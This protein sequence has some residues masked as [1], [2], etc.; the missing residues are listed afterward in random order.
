MSDQFIRTQKLLGDSGFARLQGAFVVVVGLGAVGSYAV[1]ALARSGVGRMRLIDFDD[2]SITNIN[3]QLY[4]LHSTIGRRKA[5]LAAERVRDINPDCK[6]EFADTFVHTDTLD[7]VLAGEPDVVID[8]I[9]SLN[10]K[11]ALLA[12]VMERG[13]K[14]FSSMGAA[15]RRDP[16]KVVIGDI[17]KTMNCPLARLVR[18]RLRRYH[19]IKKGITCVSSTE[20]AP[21]AAEVSMEEDVTPYTGRGRAR[22]ALGSLPTITGIFGLTLA[23]AVIDYLSSEK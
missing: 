21:D 2:V 17:S 16:T 18:K 23:N 7:E 15:L 6:I 10:P 1:E 5:E 12:G 9:D 11:V 8:A 22:P 14:V 19:D 3:R 20:L 4:A 13:L